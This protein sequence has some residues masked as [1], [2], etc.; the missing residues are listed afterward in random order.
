MPYNIYVNPQNGDNIVVACSDCHQ[1]LASCHSPFDGDLTVSAAKISEIE[2]HA[3]EC[4]KKSV[5]LAECE[6][7]NHDLDAVSSVFL[8]LMDGEIVTRWCKNCGAVVVDKDV[9]GCTQRGVVMKIKS[10]LLTRVISK[11]EGG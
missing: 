3:K 5:I 10:P 8:N 11:G 7:G 4:P 1:V 6:K 2:R 9:S